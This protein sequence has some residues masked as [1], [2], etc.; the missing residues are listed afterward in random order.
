MET[1]YQ[2]YKRD[3]K[4]L[5]NLMAAVQRAQRYLETGKHFKTYIPYYSGRIFVEA[6][7]GESAPRTWTED[8]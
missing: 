6:I 7:P 3:S 2:R 4:N 8:Y 5:E 1:T